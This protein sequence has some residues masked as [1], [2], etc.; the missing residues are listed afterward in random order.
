MSQSI[1]RPATPD[2]LFLWVMHRF[3]ERFDRHAVLKGGMALRL[4]DCPRTTN[5]IDYVF[6][7]F[8][9]KNDVVDD[10]RATL[11]TLPDA[12]VELRVHSKMI[13]AQVALDDAVI[14]VEANVA[15]EC[16]SEPM[17]TADYA[18]GLGQ[19]S[20]IVRIM[21]PDVALAQKLAAWNE[22]RLLRDLYDAW[23][24]HVRV[25]AMPHGQTLERRLARIDSRI[26]ALRRR[27]SMSAEDF[28]RELR[29][30]AA[31]IDQQ[32]VEAELAPMLPPDDVVGLAS[33]LRSGILGL[34]ERMETA[35]GGTP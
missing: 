15:P 20:R 2:G 21:T 24:L 5:D 3:A 19:P 29:E 14:Q 9:S 30:E 26:P 11:E 18:R 32:R 28:L 12:A 25:G 1:A 27:H 4:R 7:P 33:R 23:F 6:V 22:R 31:S 13:R 16:P 35:G 8:D 17:P 34:V 10:I